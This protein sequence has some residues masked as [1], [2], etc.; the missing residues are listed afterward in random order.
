[1]RRE[2]EVS[3]A[4]CGRSR[5]DQAAG[6]YKP[7]HQLIA[8]ARRPPE[9]ADS[10]CDGPEHVAMPLSRMAPIPRP[11]AARLRLL[12]A[13]TVLGVPSTTQAQP[14][15]PA[16]A[17]ATALVQRYLTRYFAMYPSRATQA[18]NHEYDQQLEQF[19]VGQRASW[20]DLNA[21]VLR[22][23]ARMLGITGQGSPGT[24][25]RPSVN[26]SAAP[27]AGPLSA[28]A[29]LDLAVLRTQ[30]EREWFDYSV[31]R[32]PERDPLFWSQSVG[33]AVVFLLVRDDRPLTERVAAVRARVQRIPALLDEG[34]RALRTAPESLIVADFARGA[35]RQAAAGATFYRDG[36]PRIAEPLGT[37]VVAATAREGAQAAQAL[38]RFAAFLDSLATGAR[39][40][41][42]LGADYAE[43][44]RVE[45]G[46]QEPVDSVLARAERDLVAVR[47]EAATYARRN[48]ATIGSAAPLPAD[49]RGTVAAAFA[50]VEA[51]RD[52]S[53]AE[54]LAYWRSLPD[55]LEAFV[56]ATAITALPLP[57]TLTVDIAPAFLAGQS[58][59]GVYPAGPYAPTA[60]TILYVPV[61]A[62]GATR[63][64]RDVFFRDFNRPFTK[65]IAAHE[66][67]PGHYAQLKHSARHARAVR[68]V[69]ADGV[70]TEGWGTFCERILLDAG[71][72]GPLEML[73]HYKKAM[74]NIARTV[75]DIRVHTRD[76]SREAMVRF[77]R[78]EA[79][80]G[81]QL[82]NNMWTRTLTTAPQITTYY[83]GDRQ[84]RDLYEEVRARDGAA[85]SLPAF[86]DAMVAEGS[87]PVPALRQRLLSR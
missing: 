12:L 60:P 54:Y 29:R 30:A 17:E 10:W 77:V 71:W 80:Q 11:S 56:T 81:E 3:L 26:G 7:A 32:R 63:E 40:T 16:D 34:M 31:R 82:A 21:E 46:V 22:T 78:D 6:R 49:D 64:A 72:G 85:F 4:A 23:T 37:D 67:M 75:V 15:S 8:S 1:M 36:I 57:R 5:P 39:G 18:G 41:P 66:L 79:L 24:A 13:L 87:V 45:T 19:T 53:V 42:R 59:G 70:F 47:A 83:L 61:P 25:G 73:A 74:E 14:A 38:E 68:S 20:T 48:W 52:T 50:R 43:V 27:A 62:A 51:V 9:V 44:F 76:M 65:M 33:Q 55:S 28:D 86:M 58:V 84:I 69:F 35:A 2:S